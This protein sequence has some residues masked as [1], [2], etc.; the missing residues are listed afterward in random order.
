[1]KKALLVPSAVA[2]SFGLSALAAGVGGCKSS[3]GSGEEDAGGAHSASSSGGDGSGGVA[4]AA[5][6]A[7]A[8]G[9]GGAGASTSHAGS[10]GL[11]EGG[12]SNT[13][14]TAPGALPTTTF[15]YVRSVTPDND[16]LVSL[17]YVSGDTGV[18]ADL[19]GDGSDGW[20]IWGHTI[21]PDRTRIAIASLYGPTKADNV[22]GLATRRIWTMAV[23]GS[24]LQRRTPVFDNDGGGRTNYSIAV[25]DPVFSKDGQSIIFDFGTWW[26]EGNTLQ[27]GSFPW[28]VPTSGDGL[29]EPF[30]TVASCSVIDP[31][32]NP[33]TGEVLFVHSVCVNASDE[34][35]F[36]YPETGSGKPVKLVD[37]GFGAG[38]VDPVLE[39]ASWLADGSAFV[40]VGTIEVTRGDVTDTANS[41][42]AYDMATGNI[43]TLLIPDVDTSVRNVA[44]APN[45]DGIVYCLAHDDVYDLHVIDLT[46]DPPVE[47]AITD[48][49][50][51]CSP[52]F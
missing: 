18:V 4:D 15:L 45:G 22:T 10:P 52:S 21:S 35:I 24:D 2:L 11:G 1:M 17:D 36:L 26:Y 40:F 8:S 31:S 19:Q 41:I 47:S 48:D 9:R 33:A 30:P 43:G 5:A 38:A 46:V 28:L 16:Q 27:G 49:G 23:D 25:Q 29:P 7:D 50:I 20:E 32:V 34:G 44:I 12:S 6:G 37:R 14:P 3:G 51:S 39:K 42:L 13:D